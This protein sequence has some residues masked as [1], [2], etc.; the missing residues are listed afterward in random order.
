MLAEA[1]TE[2]GFAELK[3]AEVARRLDVTLQTLYNHVRDREELLHLA[4]EVLEERYGLPETDELDWADWWRSSARALKKLYNRTPG[5]ATILMSRPLVNVPPLI[6]SW[7]RAQEIAER[8]GFTPAA[9]LWANMTL[10]EFVYS[11]AAREDQS[12]RQAGRAD[13]CE[14]DPKFAAKA[15]RFAAAIDDVRGRSFDDR[16]ERTLDA[17]IAGL[18]AVRASEPA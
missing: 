10:H 17:M 7:E 8:S 18:L 14:V 13:I 4:A 16:F 12:A 15:P 1:A 5:L 2:F 11:W 3:L 9:A 6:H